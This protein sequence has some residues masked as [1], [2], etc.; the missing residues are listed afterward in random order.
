M[1]FLAI[2]KDVPVEQ[3]IYSSICEL[4][5]ANFLDVVCDNKIQS[6]TRPNEK[7]AI[8]ELEEAW[9]KIHDEY[10]EAIKDK[11]TEYILRVQYRIELL[12][13]KV[14]LVQTCANSL[15]GCRTLRDLTNMVVVPPDFIITIQK[16]SGYK[17][18]FDITNDEQFEKDIQLAEAS[19]KRYEIEIEA[20]Q[21]ELDILLPKDKV[22][23]VTREAFLSTL[24]RMSRWANI[25]YKPNEITVFEFVRNLNDWKQE[26]ENETA[27]NTKRKNKT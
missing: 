6:L 14:M 13:Q 9:A 3:R 21:Q 7:A 5:L 11:D 26:I 19:V 15:R 17:G 18:V 25:H 12:R 20:K 22:V 24:S 4:P 23:A 1:K 10:I 2:F 27:A 8:S 16:E